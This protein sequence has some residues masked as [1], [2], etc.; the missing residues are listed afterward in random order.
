MAPSPPL[1]RRFSARATP[2]MQ[3]AADWY[4]NGTMTVLSTFP[5]HRA[6]EDHL[7]LVRQGTIA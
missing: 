4:F 1:Y 5:R 3:S 2:D 7:F 6:A